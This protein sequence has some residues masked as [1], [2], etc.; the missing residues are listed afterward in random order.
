MSYIIDKLFE[1]VQKFSKVVRLLKNPTEENSRKVVKGWELLDFDY[2]TDDEAIIDGIA[3]N[4]LKTNILQAAYDEN[5]NLCIRYKGKNIKIDYPDNIR[6]KDVTIKAVNKIISQ[7]YEIRL[8]RDSIGTE[9]LQFY[10]L[11]HEDWANWEYYYEE[12]VPLLFSKIDENTKIFT[13]TDDEI[14]R[15]VKENK[16]KYERKRIRRERLLIIKSGLDKSRKQAQATLSGETLQEALGRYADTEKWVDEKL[17]IFEGYE[18]EGGRFL[19]PISDYDRIAENDYQLKTRNERRQLKKIRNFI[20]SNNNDK[21]LSIDEL[22]LI[23]E[24]VENLC[25]HDS[26]VI[27][28]AD[29]YWKKFHLLLSGILAVV[30]EEAMEELSFIPEDRRYEKLNEEDRAHIDEGRELKRNSLKEW[31][32]IHDGTSAIY[33]IHWLLRDGHARRYDEFAACSDFEEAME[34]DRKISIFWLKEKQRSDDN[35]ISDNATLDEVIALEVKYYIREHYDEIQKHI[36]KFLDKTTPDWNNF[37][38][39]MIWKKNEEYLIEVFMKEHRKY[40]EDTMNFV[41]LLGAKKAVCLDAWDIGRCANVIRWSYSLGYIGEQTAWEFLDKNSRRAIKQYQSFGSFAH[42]YM[43]GRFFWQSGD[44]GCMDIDS[45]Y[46]MLDAI[47]YLF[48]K[49]KGMWTQN[50]WISELQD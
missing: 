22:H 42:D 35:P 11:P 18:D 9:R 34:A 26:I 23:A 36:R 28:S 8:F 10:V 38:E 19:Q 30:N 32:D 2:N 13:L 24:T 12:T 5:K 39:A 1:I 7:E 46:M 48:D 6:N 31:W 15:I 47:R 21:N 16:D 45:T 4:I 41:R 44:S 3:A 14:Q 20:G 49:D 43:L 37:D 27:S 33:T 17:K 25:T 50:P 40:V 29:H